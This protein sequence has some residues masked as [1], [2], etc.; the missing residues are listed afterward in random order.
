MPRNRFIAVRL[1]ALIDQPGML[2]SHVVS[3]TAYDV[4]SEINRL[5]NALLG[6]MRGAPEGSHAHITAAA[7]LELI[8]Q[9]GRVKET[10]DE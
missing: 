5:E 6:I 1:E 7:A 8:D 9:D 10:G 3:E 2:S 4:K